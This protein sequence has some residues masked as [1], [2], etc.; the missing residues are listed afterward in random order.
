M[1]TN[2]MQ[3]VINYV[4]NN[5][6]NLKQQLTNQIN[7]WNEDQDHIIDDMGFDTLNEWESSCMI[8]I[9]ERVLE[10]TNL[11]NEPLGVDWRGKLLNK[12]KELI[13]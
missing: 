11:T 13:K 1:E 6:D 12:V 3:T 7:W 10:A 9:G 2:Q 4:N 5:I 8:S